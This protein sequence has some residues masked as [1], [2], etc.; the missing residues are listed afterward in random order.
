MINYEIQN[1]LHP[2]KLTGIAIKKTQGV[3][4]ATDFLPERSF[5][6]WSGYYKEYG[7]IGYAQLAPEVAEGGRD[8][9]LNTAYTETSFTMKEYRIGG[10]ISE[11][12]INFLMNKNSKVA[13]SSGRQLVTDEIELLA[14]TLALREEKTIIDTI[15]AGASSSNAVSA[16]NQWDESTGTPLTNLRTACKNILDNQHTQADTLLM[17]TNTELNLMEHSDVKDIYK[18]GGNFGNLTAKIA[19]GRSRAIPS[20]AGLDVYVTD[21]VYAPNTAASILAAATTSKMVKDD[22]AVVFKRGPS[23]GLTYVAEGLTTRRWAEEETRSVRVQLF[24]TFI[25][26]I[27]RSSQI[28]IVSNIDN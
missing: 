12:A 13:V 3:M 15:V 17:S 28:A 21:A 24:K 18:Y 22:F 2:K 23:L 9:L 7:S 1:D 19:A 20:I 4:F 16:S 14:E 25:P 27:F 26:V 11:R 6:E 8:Q 5:P 10:R